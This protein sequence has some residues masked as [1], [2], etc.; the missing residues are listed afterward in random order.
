MRDGFV[1]RAEKAP[2][3]RG[4]RRVL[5][6]LGGDI[7][8]AA[9]FEQA[10]TDDASIAGVLM[11]G[12]YPSEW[13]TPALRSAIDGGRFVVLVDTLQNALVDDADVVL[14]GA[15]WMEKAGTFESAT[16]RLQ[17]FQRAVSPQRWCK[18]DSQIAIDLLARLR[19]ESPAAFCD[20]TTRETMADHGLTVMTQ[21]VHHPPAQDVQAE[22]DMHLIVL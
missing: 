6:S 18:N 5:E 16:G 1:I 17:S 14:P 15:T 2:N 7:L 8:D 4:V 12:N 19:G 3:A 9:G 20:A 13:V 11:T 22:S 10:L 21:E